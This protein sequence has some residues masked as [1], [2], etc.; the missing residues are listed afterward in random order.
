MDFHELI[1]VR[2]SV[3]GYKPE[4][5]AEDQIARVLSAAVIA[6]TAANLQPW[7]FI[8]VTCPETR[9]KFKT[10]Y[11]RDWFWQAPVLVVACV[12]P[13][14]AWHR[15]DGYCSAEVDVAIAMDHLVLAATAEGLG[16]CWVCAFDENKTKELL[17]IPQEVRVI[18]M[19]PVGF[20]AEV[21]ER[22]SAVRKRASELIKRDRW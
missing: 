4:E 14:K 20:P 11:S 17:G 22:R 5:P 18:A 10:V 1:R 21:T 6:P 19:T 13:G 12:D 7:T 3:R 16:T 15:A 2:R 9:A 8:V